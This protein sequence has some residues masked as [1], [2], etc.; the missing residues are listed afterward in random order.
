MILLNENL[1]VPKELVD[2]L[3]TKMV[4]KIH[5]TSNSLRHTSAPTI[6]SN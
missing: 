3:I 1:N 5:L 4:S 2:F 6:K